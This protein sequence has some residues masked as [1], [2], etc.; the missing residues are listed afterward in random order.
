VVDRAMN[1]QPGQHLD[2][3]MVRGIGQDDFPPWQSAQ[4]LNQPDVALHQWAEFSHRM[5]RLQK[6]SWF[7]LMTLNQT[8]EGGAVAQPVFPSECI[9]PVAVNL[10]FLRDEVRHALVDAGD[11]LGDRVVQ[12]VIQ[13]EEPDWIQSGFK[14]ESKPLACPCQGQ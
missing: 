3:V 11:D 7:D 12:R 5:R 9:G 10:E 6:S 13:I 1:P 8:E 4:R 14:A 2:R